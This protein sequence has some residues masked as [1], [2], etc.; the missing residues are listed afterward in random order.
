MGINKF[1]QTELTQ[2]VT[3]TFSHFT[4]FE[5][6]LLYGRAWMG[7]PNFCT[8]LRNLSMKIDSELTN[9]TATFHNAFRFCLFYLSQ[10]AFGGNQTSTQNS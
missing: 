1:I 4:D 2:I 5:V 7:L 9:N 8:E 3:P 6:F 10:R